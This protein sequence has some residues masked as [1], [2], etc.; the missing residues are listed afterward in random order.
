MCEALLCG[1][2]VI[3]TPTDGIADK[4]IPGK[5]GYIFDFDDMNTFL[6]ILKYIE[7]K[8][9][10]VITPKECRDSMIYLTTEKPL[11]DFEKKMVDGYKRYCREYLI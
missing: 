11:E 1:M 7:E 9:F 6:K 5:N 10:P 3:S 4:I 2:L 8:K